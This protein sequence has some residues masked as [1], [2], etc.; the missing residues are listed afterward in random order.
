MKCQTVVVSVVIVVISSIASFAREKG[1][2]IRVSPKEIEIELT[3]EEA[4]VSGG[5]DLGKIIIQDGWDNQLRLTSV[6]TSTNV[7]AVVYDLTHR[8]PGGSAEHGFRI[9]TR[10]K[11]TDQ[12]GTLKEWVKVSTS[13]PDFATI[14]IP[15]TYH[16]LAGV[17]AIPRTLL[18]NRFLDEES[19]K[20]VRL[21]TSAREGLEIQQATADAPWLSVTPSRV[22]ANTIDLRISVAEQSGGDILRSAI[23]VRM[24]R[25]EIAQIVVPVVILP[26]VARDDP[27]LLAV[28]A[29]ANRLNREV[30]SSF[31]CQYTST[32]SR[33]G[34]REIHQ[35]H[36]YGFAGDRE[37]HQIEIA[38][39]PD[40]ALHYVRNGRQARLRPGSTVVV[41]GNRDRVKGSDDLFAAAADA[42][43]Y[44]IPNLDHLNPEYYRVSSVREDASGG[45]RQII[46][47]IEERLAA[48]TKA[49]SRHTL[50]VHLSVEHGLLPVQIDQQPPEGAGLAD[51]FTR[52]AAVTRILKFETQGGVFYLPA[53]FHHETYRSGKLIDRAYS[54]VNEES[55]EINTVLPRDA[56]WIAIRPDDT[57]ADAGLAPPSSRSP[58]Q[59]TIPGVR[60]F[61]GAK[62][63][64]RTPRGDTMEAKIIFGQEFAPT[65]AASLVG[66]RL[67]SPPDLDIELSTDRYQGKML[68]LCFFD[69]GQRSSRHCIDAL[70][71][72][73]EA[74]QQQGVTIVAIQAA[75]IDESVWKTW[76]KERSAELSFGQVRKDAEKVKA[77]WGVQSLPC[78]ILTDKDHI[79]RMAGFG[80]DELQN[81]IE[82][83]AKK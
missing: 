7:A 61:W 12:V 50:T 10:L 1:E 70:A 31:R 26:R 79:I 35:T 39:A 41:I 51:S 46:V 63:S 3:R 22:D 5:E 49:A 83:V 20:A 75:P 78:L 16:V 67:P 59:I 82:E 30:L 76:I 64:F 40:E 2:A 57:V 6:Q 19:T 60:D 25:P 71:Q 45:H 44:V 36:R 47:T 23:T 4:R 29:T 33:P 66:R 74:L 42:A 17:Q 27:R 48:T 53:E 18:V 28:I 38:G 56:A 37:Y 24:T 58:V 43:G 55:I 14:T 62:T 32:F 9:D 54:N 73:T 52:K 81:R 77:A 15:I 11:P 72:Q 21:T 68:L 65:Q 34:R 13:H 80:L 69:L 8:F